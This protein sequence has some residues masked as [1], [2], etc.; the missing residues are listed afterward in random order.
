MPEKIL[1]NVLEAC[2]VMG[3]SKATFYKLSKTGNAPKILK[4]GTRSLVAKDDIEEWV[5]RLR[6]VA[7]NGDRTPET[8]KGA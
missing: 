1:Y 6:A 5:E 7:A 3:V 8:K 4:V 2:Q